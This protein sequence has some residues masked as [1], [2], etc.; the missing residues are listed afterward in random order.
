MAKIETGNGMFYVLGDQHTYEAKIEILENC[1]VDNGIFI[2]TG[3][4]IISPTDMKFGREKFK[5]LL[6]N[7]KINSYSKKVRKNKW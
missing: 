1:T 7:H 3:D 5:L 4:F 6:D 2:D